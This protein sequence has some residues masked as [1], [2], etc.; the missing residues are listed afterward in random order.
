[1]MGIYKVVSPTN[2]IYIGQSIDIKKRWNEYHKLLNCKSQI[3][4][5]RSFLKHGVENHIFEVIAECDAEE[6]NNFE[7][8]FQEVHCS[9]NEKVGLNCI[10]TKTNDKSGRHSDESRAKISESMKGRPK[11][12][13]SK[14]K[15]S[16]TRRRISA[17]NQIVPKAKRPRRRNVVF[18]E[19]GNEIVRI[20]KKRILSEQAKRN[21]GEAN[22]GR[23]ISEET[24]RKMSNAAMGHKRNLG[25]TGRKHSEETKNKISNSCK[26][27][28][29]KNKI[30]EI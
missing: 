10:L 27:I 24:R 4:L 20:R 15:M 14:K 12:E 7:R 23:V 29:H 3:R 18:D 26:G 8:Y 1:M 13:E 17:L 22:T 6:L 30:K 28:T 11:S 25:K 16:D 2:K 5:Y 9:T 19:N 21:I